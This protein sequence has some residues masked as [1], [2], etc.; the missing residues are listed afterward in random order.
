MYVMQFSVRVLGGFPLSSF[1]T[2]GRMFLLQRQGAAEAPTATE[3]AARTVRSAVAGRAATTHRLLLGDA[4][5]LGGLL[6]RG[7]MEQEGFSVV[8]VDP[9][10]GILDGVPWDKVAWG[11]AALEPQVH[12]G[13][14][15]YREAGTPDHVAAH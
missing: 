2:V 3:D 4:F 13:G 6:V 11:T 12:M 5:Q 10:Q 15:G 14:L 1:P 8:H 9:P 7:A